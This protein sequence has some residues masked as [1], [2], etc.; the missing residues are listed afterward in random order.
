MQLL[1]DFAARTQPQP[2]RRTR[3]RFTPCAVLHDTMAQPQQQ[4]AVTTGLKEWASV[5]S[6]VEA[7]ESSVLL[8]KGGIAEK[9]FKVQSRVFAFYPSGFHDA[10]RFLTAAAVV[11]HGNS[12]GTTPGENALLTVLGECTAAWQTDDGPGALAALAAFHPWNSELLTTR[13]NWRPL[14][15]LTIVEVRAYRLPAPYVLAGSPDHGGCKSWVEVEPVGALDLQS[16]VPVMDDAA[17]ALRQRDVRAALARVG[18]VT[19]I[20]V[21][22]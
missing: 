20:D 3:R 17:W 14:D 4:R 16:A 1:G 10:A 6:S 5:V 2:L 15:K 18:N 19:P 11:A 8:R 12:V 7:G 22:L 21:P 13:L 9:G